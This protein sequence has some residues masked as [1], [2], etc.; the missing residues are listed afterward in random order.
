MFD[1]ELIKAKELE[2]ES[3]FKCDYGTNIRWGS[4]SNSSSGGSS[5]EGSKNK[6]AKIKVGSGCYFGDAGKIILGD[7]V[8][9]GPNVQI[10]TA[11]DGAEEGKE[12]AGAIFIG[13]KSSFEG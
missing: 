6:A 13:R 10:L 9:V 4:I 3:P 11:K 1:L 2:I 5:S 8:T 7:G 12:M